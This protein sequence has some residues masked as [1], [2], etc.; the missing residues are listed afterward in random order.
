MFL[1][2]DAWCKLYGSQS[3]HHQDSVLYQPFGDTFHVDNQQT[4]RGNSSDWLQKFVRQAWVFPLPL[5]S[6]GPR[7]WNG[8]GGGKQKRAMRPFIVCP[9]LCDDGSICAWATYKN[10]LCQSVCPLLSPFFHHA[11]FFLRVSD[12]VRRYNFARERRQ[13]R[14]LGRRRLKL[15]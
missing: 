7:V 14:C 12:I 3:L 15:W 11:L 2:R 10:W 13:N 9:L 4:D 1:F 6:G 8:E 5:Q